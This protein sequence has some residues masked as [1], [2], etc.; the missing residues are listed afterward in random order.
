MIEK[1]E[2][3][4]LVKRPQ[5]KEVVGVKWVHKTKLNYN[6]SVKRYETRLVAKNYSQLP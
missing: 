1:N 2:T 5:D 4:Q 6:I 3:R